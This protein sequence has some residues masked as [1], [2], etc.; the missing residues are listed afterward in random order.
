MVSTAAWRQDGQVIV[1][2]T[3]AKGDAGSLAGAFKPGPNRVALPSTRARS[4]APK[5]GEGKLH[6]PPADGSLAWA[7]GAALDSY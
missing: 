1:A 4:S 2:L 7:A 6:T 3:E 5:D